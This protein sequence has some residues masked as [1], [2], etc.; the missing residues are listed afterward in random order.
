VLGTAA[1]NICI[2]SNNLDTNSDVECKYLSPCTEND[3]PVPPAGYAMACDGTCDAN[4]DIAFDMEGNV[5]GTFGG[6]LSD[7]N[8][9]STVQAC[10]DMCEELAGC[11]GFNFVF[12]PGAYSSTD[13][14]R[15]VAKA[16][17]GTILTS[18][19][20]M[21]VYARTDGA[22]IAPPSPPQLA[23]LNTADASTTEAVLFSVP[24]NVNSEDALTAT[25]KVSIQSAI[26]SA[27]N[28]AAEYVQ[29]HFV[30]GSIVIMAV[31]YVPSGSTAASI[32]S[33]LSTALGTSSLASA[34]LGVTVTS[35]PTTEQTT[36]TAAV[37][38][39][40]EAALNGWANAVA[41]AVTKGTQMAIGILIG[42]IVG[43]SVVV[44]L[45]ILLFCYCCKCCCF[46][47]KIAAVSS[48]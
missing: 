7:A 13:M 32:E 42:I 30:L 33:G 44:V 19:Y 38:S 23:P 28:V 48:S 47:K 45:V 41:N 46:K 21:A 4:T 26:A 3:A 5:G 18:R 20:G 25:Q 36:P 11:C 6:I 31:V 39:V 14:G 27:A 16:C 40:S 10:A 43:A 34:A 9:S 8:C 15:C 17:G 22:V 37:T 35:D 24:T 29:L 12:N 1:A 2:N